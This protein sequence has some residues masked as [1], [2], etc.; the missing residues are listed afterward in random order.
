MFPVKSNMISDFS[1]PALADR[2]GDVAS[3]EQGAVFHSC[4]VFQ[5]DDI[6]SGYTEK[7]CGI[8]LIGKLPERRTYP[9]DF[10]R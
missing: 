2:Q 9:E 10:A 7:V 4:N 8:Q 3:Q 1:A 5:I 6:I